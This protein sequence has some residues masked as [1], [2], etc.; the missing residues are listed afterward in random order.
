MHASGPDRVELERASLA[1]LHTLAAERDLPRFRAMRRE[2][3]IDALAGDGGAAV[4]IDELEGLEEPARPGMTGGPPGG[5]LGEELHTDPDDQDV[6]ESEPRDWRE[7]A[8][9]EP[10]E[11]EPSEPRRRG[12]S[13]GG[14]SRGDAASKRG[15]RTRAGRDESKRDEREVEDREVEDRDEREVEERD[16]REREPMQSRA[17]ILDLVPD[18]FGFLRIEGFGRSGDDVFV[19]RSQVRSLGLRQGDEVGGPLQPLRRSERH[20]SLAEAETVNGRP[21]SELGDR[22]SFDSLTPVFPS[23]RLP[24]A[25]SAGDVGL[26]M[27]D[28]IAPLLKGQRY[29][30]ASAPRCGATTLLH[31][32]VRSA[33]AGG[34]T[35]MVVL[36][37][38]RPEEVTDWARA[39]DAPVHATSSDRSAEAQVQFVALALE[40]VKRLAEEGQD[41]LLVIDSISRLARAHSLSRPR[42]RRGRDG[43]VAEADGASTAVQAAKK[44]F[45][46]ARAMEEGGS[47][48]IVASARVESGS[49]LEALLHEAL[50]DVASAE[51]RLG[52]EIARKSLFPAIDARRSFIRLEGGTAANV[53][54]ERQRRL[55]QSLEPLRPAEAWQHLA[56]RIRDTGSNEQVLD[57]AWGAI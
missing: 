42:G 34:L 48:T 17:G 31:D 28:L 55:G 1:D 41:V 25:L 12:R 6:I 29:L 11:R 46:A 24:L 18:G 3:L 57:A 40:R 19:S 39:T 5:Q 26:R 14:R 9:R 21:A 16:E 22:P 32:V 35:P 53:L 44:L 54:A 4:E 38:A 43:D 50:A 52:E 15:A 45:S 13:R 36:V 56:G 23:E 49:T 51:L 7:A 8:V 37:D 20:A 10:I 30:I 2:Q 47:L 27:L 33:L